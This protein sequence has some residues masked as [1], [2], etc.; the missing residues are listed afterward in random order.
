MCSFERCWSSVEQ[1]YC[2]NAWIMLI[3]YKDF[4]GHFHFHGPCDFP[5]GMWSPSA[6]GIWC[7]HNPGDLGDFCPTYN[8]GTFTNTYENSNQAWYC[9]KI[10]LQALC[11]MELYNPTGKFRLQP[12]SSG[13]RPILQTVKKN[14]ELE[15]GRFETDTFAVDI[16]GVVGQR[17]WWPLVLHRAWIY[18]AGDSLDHSFLVGGWEPDFTLPIILG[19]SSSQLT[20]SDFS[21]QP[22]FFWRDGNHLSHESYLVTSISWHLGSILGPKTGDETG[23]RCCIKSRESMHRFGMATT[24]TMFANHFATSS[25][26]SFAVPALQA[27][28]YICIYIYIV[29]ISIYI[30]IYSS[31][32]PCSQ[33]LTLK[34]QLACVFFNNLWWFSGLIQWREATTRGFAHDA[35]PPALGSALAYLE[36]AGREC[37]WISSVA[38]SGTDLLEVPAIRSM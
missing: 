4:V 12:A 8:H 35:G 23:M 31:K 38:I 32:W 19:M 3:R 5:L 1:K 11:F 30:Y 13:M 10:M 15:S 21:H 9:L 14:L 29:I 34:I 33:D 2:L 24:A 36:K 37:W 26:W 20:N 18:T 27:S 25:N 17:S 6:S 28:H 7:C 22:F 16:L